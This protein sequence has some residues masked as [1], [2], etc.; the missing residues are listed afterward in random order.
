MLRDGIHGHLM[1]RLELRL[2]LLG[3]CDFRAK[4]IE[5]MLL[6]VQPVVQLGHQLFVGVFPAKKRE[7]TRERAQ[8]ANG[9]KSTLD[10]CL[11]ALMKVL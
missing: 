2:A 1:I 7:S 5:L 6:S 4:L 8:S 10:L 3:H 9:P 11:A